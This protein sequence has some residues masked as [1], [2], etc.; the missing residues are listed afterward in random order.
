[1]GE[2]KEGR[3]ANVLGTTKIRIAH[4]SFD[5]ESSLESSLESPKMQL[6]DESLAQVRLSGLCLLLN[7]LIVLWLQ[8]REQEVWLSFCPCVTSCGRSEGNM[9]EMQLMN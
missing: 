1:M 2:E 4:K 6:E 5:L 7:V 3:G 8:E 9:V